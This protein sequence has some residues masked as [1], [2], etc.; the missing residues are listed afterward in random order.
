MQAMDC[1]VFKARLIE[2]RR[3][4]KWTQRQLGRRMAA[5]ARQ[6]GRPIPPVAKSTISSYETGQRTP[7]PLYALLLCRALERDPEELGL[8]DVL[9]SER[10]QE[11]TSTGSV[12]EGWTTRLT[13]LMPALPMS[14]AGSWKV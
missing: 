11:L 5:E 8:A 3:G 4:R 1:D 6:Y 7:D 9:T 13:P 12:I 14:T 2:Y 10:I